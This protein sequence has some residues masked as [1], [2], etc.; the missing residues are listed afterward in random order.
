ML[1]REQDRGTAFLTLVALLLVVLLL[2]A[3]G[4]G[5]PEPEACTPDEQ[6]APTGR[7][8]VPTTPCREQAQ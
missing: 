6:T 7:E 3:C 1:N 5:D 8:Q 4:G 2:A